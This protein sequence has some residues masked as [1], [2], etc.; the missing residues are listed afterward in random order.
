MAILHPH[1]RQQLHAAAV[2]ATRPAALDEAPHDKADER[3]SAPAI[4][5]ISLAVIVWLIAVSTVLAVI[6]ISALVI[7]ANWADV[8]SWLTD[9]GD[10]LM[11]ASLA[12]AVRWSTKADDTGPAIA[13]RF[14]NPAGGVHV[15]RATLLRC[16]DDGLMRVQMLDTGVR[17]IVHPA[18]IVATPEA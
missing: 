3:F 15:R 11:L 6:A 14:A 13:L 8:I 2:R 10:T 9:A 4:D 17:C 1:L 7:D 12:P 18:S 16:F 5:G